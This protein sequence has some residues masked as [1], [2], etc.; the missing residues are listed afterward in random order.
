M[1]LFVPDPFGALVQFQRALDNFRES[2]WF[3]DSPSGGG[4]FPPLNVFSKG[5]DIVLIS[6]VPGINKRELKIEVK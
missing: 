1:A 4:A 2:S 6:E 5:D 3:D